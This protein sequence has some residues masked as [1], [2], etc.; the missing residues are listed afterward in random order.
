MRSHAVI[1]DER[2]ERRMIRRPLKARVYLDQAGGSI[3]AKVRFAY[4]DIELDP[5]SRMWGW[6]TN[7]GEMMR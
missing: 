7:T 2:L 5:F 1:L 4:G 6:M 3:V